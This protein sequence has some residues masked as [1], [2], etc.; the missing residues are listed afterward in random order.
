M[1]QDLSD[2]TIVVDRSGSMESCRTDAEGGVNAFVREQ[3]AL[4]GQVTLTLVQFDTEYEFVHKGVPIRE[5]PPFHLVPRGGTALLDAV[6]RAINEAGARLA[7]LP[8]EQRPGLVAFVIVTDGEENSSR[9]FSLKQVREMIIH[10]R[11]KY[12]W[13]FTFLGADDSAF[14]QAESMGM[15]AGDAAQYST[16]KADQ[17]FAAASMK[18]ARTRAAFSKGEK[19]LDLEF[20][21]EERDRMK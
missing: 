12:N 9:E 6:G 1:N 5:I 16:A 7:S 17:A 19:N 3:A 2:I 11:E 18:I 20:T 10:Q 15:A 14:S 13:R 21:D 8:E 4:P